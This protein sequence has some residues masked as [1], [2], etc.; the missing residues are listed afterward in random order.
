MTDTSL[1][2]EKE[3]MNKLEVSSRQS[4]RNYTNRHGFHKPVRPHPKAY[5]REAVDG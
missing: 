4:I 2:P 3:V 1:I 5:L